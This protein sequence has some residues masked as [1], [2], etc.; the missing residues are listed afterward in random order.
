MRDTLRERQRHR[1]K[2]KQT[3]YREP[4]AVL[5]PRTPGSQLEPKADAQ[6]LNHPGTPTITSY[7]DLPTDSLDP[8][9]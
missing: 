2:E 1:Q 8:I 4:D 6:P 5:D 7:T 9:N 3:P